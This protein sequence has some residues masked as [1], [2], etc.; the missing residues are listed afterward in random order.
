MSDPWMKFYPS[1][2]RSD[3]VLRLCS[4][5]ARGLWVEMLCIMHE[6]VPYGSLLVNGK[7]IDKRQL[8]SLVGM[9]EKECAALLME[10]EIGG[11]FSRDD[12]G[13]VFSRRMRRDAEK[14]A[15]D[16]A[17]GK[18]GGNPK[19]MAGVNPPVKGEDKAHIPEARIQND[20]IG[21]ARESPSSFTVGSKHLV[22]VFWRSLGIDSPLQV[23]PEL[24]GS[25]QRALAWHEAGWTADM[26]A[27]EARRIGPGKPLTY[28]E[29]VFATAFAKL[30]TPLP[31]VKIKEREE[32][33]V[34]AKPRAQTG[35]II[36][37]AERL[38]GK[39]AEF[40][41]G[42]SGDIGVRG[43]EGISPPRLLPHGGS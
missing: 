19:V 28:Y 36:Q 33:H 31:I 14:A 22:D 1:D 30:Q 23:P 8:A 25:D 7:R 35:N 37:A 18:K 27:A 20:R 9:S 21:D 39:I 34:H 4:M 17:N 40:A 2:W 43:A 10:L 32:I 12:D 26:I 11:V 41:A 5:A 38:R 16:K 6:A 3:P 24:A 29:K 42:T 15:R 13:T